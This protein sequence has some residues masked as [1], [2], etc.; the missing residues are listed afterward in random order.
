MKDGIFSVNFTSQQGKLFVTLSEV[1]FAL[2]VF[3][4]GEEINDRSDLKK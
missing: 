4:S 1:L 3:C 2:V